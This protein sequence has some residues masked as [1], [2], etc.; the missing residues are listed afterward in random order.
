MTGCYPQIRNEYVYDARLD[1]LDA[2]IA[3]IQE[4]EA[5]VHPI[6]E[7]TRWA[8]IRFRWDQA[9]RWKIAPALI[10]GLLGVLTA[11]AWIATQ[12]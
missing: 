4:Y 3:C 8:R 5:R 7:P 9:W 2:L 1:Q 10:G 6:G 11:L 12:C